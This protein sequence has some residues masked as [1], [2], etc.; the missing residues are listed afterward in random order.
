[1]LGQLKKIKFEGRLGVVAVRV[2]VGQG[3]RAAR[4]GLAPV[5]SFVRSFVRPAA[6]RSVVAAVEDF[7]EK[8][9]SAQ[10]RSVVT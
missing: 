6:G 9:R 2:V 5:R 10:K 4:V 7:L 1:M 3:P 8:G